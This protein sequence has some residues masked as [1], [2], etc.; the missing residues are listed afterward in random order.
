M[1]R[2]KSVVRFINGRLL[3]GF[4]EGFSPQ[5]DE[6]ILREPGSGAS[7]AVKVCDLKAV[8]FVRSFDGDDDYR[9]KKVYGTSPARGQ[10]VFVKFKDGESLVGFMDGSLPWS[11]GFFLSRLDKDTKGFFIYPAD[12]RANNIRVFVV[13]S[14]VSEVTV[15][16]IE[17][18][19]EA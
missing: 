9:E 4:L 6:M 12:L 11:K 17:I 3:K 13:A 2:E 16:P 5:A 18:Q 1:E 15:V 8:F 7:H 19:G 14:A 10:R